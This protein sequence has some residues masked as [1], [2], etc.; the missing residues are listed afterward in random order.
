MLE[1]AFAIPGDYNQPTGGYGYARSVKAVALEQGIRFRPVQLPGGF[2]FPS[3]QALAE[4]ERM[5]AAL[6]PDLPVLID[7]LAYGAMP[8]ELL[9]RLNRRWIAL[10]H[11]PLALETGLPSDVAAHLSVAEASALAEAHQIIVTSAATAD[12]LIQDFGVNPTKLTVAPPGVTR[13]PQAKGEANPPVLLAV[14]AL[15]PRKGYDLLIEA[16]SMIKDRAW[17]CRIVGDTSRDPATTA[18]ILDQINETGLGSRVIL[19]GTIDEAALN[20]AYDEASIFV[21]AAHFEGYGMAVADALAAGLPIVATAAAA[22]VA[23][24]PRSASRLTPVG[25]PAELAKA[26]ATLLD[27]PGLRQTLAAGAWAAGLK[28]PDWPETA[29][30]ILQSCQQAA[31]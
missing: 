17:Q 29:S 5:I 31:A 26:L 23:L 18:A 11:H 25:D 30:R 6:P 20:Q 1:I 27:D 4:T 7:G 14:G 13:R 2:P 9:R 16:L 19:T 12:L 8:A 28:L 15:T 22:T 10:C 3:D 24:A 21:H